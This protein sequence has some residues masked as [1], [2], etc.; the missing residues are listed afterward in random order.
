MSNAVLV[1]PLVDLLLRGNARTD[2]R[3]DNAQGKQPVDISRQHIIPS[4][5]GL[6]LAPDR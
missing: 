4:A 5:N 3:E 6:R 2:K 1:H